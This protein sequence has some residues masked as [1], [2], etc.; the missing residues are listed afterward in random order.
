MTRILAT[1]ALRLAICT[2]ISWAVWRWFGLAS[3]VPTLGLFGILLARP[4]L[5]L[6][7]ALARRHEAGAALSP[8][9]GGTTRFTA[10][11]S[12]C[13]TM[14]TGAAGCAWPTFARSSASPPA[15]A[16]WR[17]PIPIGVRRLGRPGEAARERGSAARP[18]AEGTCPGGRAPA[19]L[20]RARNRL[21][22][23]ARARA[24]R[25]SLDDGQDATPATDA[26]RF[27]RR[28]SDAVERPAA[29]PRMRATSEVVE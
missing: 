15:T 2:G 24:A 23:A 13:S 8:S 12:R 5:D 16:R 9:K 21:P 7:G 26:H 11:P 3:M 6:A 20:G 18:P 27:A 4:L 22:G 28:R 17:S 1:I 19:R 14:P 10:A 25:H 29:Q